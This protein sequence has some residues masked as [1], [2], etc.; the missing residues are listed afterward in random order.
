MDR[1]KQVGRAQAGRLCILVLAVLSTLLAVALEL[2]SMVGLW[3][4]LR[5]G[6]G[7]PPMSDRSR[8]LQVNA[9]YYPGMLNV[10]ENGLVLSQGLKSRIIAM[11]GQTVKYD[12][13]KSSRLLAHDEP[14]YGATIPDPRG[15]NAGGWIYLS[16]SENRYTGYGGVGAFTFNRRGKLINYRRVLKG[17]TSNCGGGTTPWGAFISCEEKS[18]GRIYQVDPTGLT[19]PQVI[20]MGK[21]TGGGIFESFAYDNRNL[22]TPQFFVTED[23]STGVVRRFIPSNPDWSNPWGILTGN[24]T[25]DYLMVDPVNKTFSWTTDL[26]AARLNA[27]KNFPYTEGIDHNQGQLYFVSKVFKSMFILNLDAGNYTNVTTKNGAFDGQPDQVVQILGPTNKNFQRL[28]W[29]FFTEDGGSTVG[30]FARN[31]LGKF[32][33]I[34]ESVNPYDETTGLAF[35]PDG[36]FMYFALQDAGITYEISRLDG[37]TFQ[38]KTLNVKYHNA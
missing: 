14:D 33:T 15:T 13:L 25:V 34:L 38:A 12:N 37:L 1:V 8:N 3:K 7:A 32:Y 36:K 16:N 21:E 22:S 18:K 24:G 31:N 28:G 2:P 23:S 17:S 10:Y 11:A 30:I 26:T 27:N 5:H 9:T 20:T 35:S 6:K 29:L 4:K 19:S